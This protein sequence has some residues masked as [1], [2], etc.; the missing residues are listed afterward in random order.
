[1]TSQLVAPPR[2]VFFFSHSHNCSLL[3][4]LQPRSCPSKLVNVCC[5][6]SDSTEAGA[7]VSHTYGPLDGSLYATVTK[8]P[9]TP[10]STQPVSSSSTEATPVDG[11]NSVLA[12]SGANSSGVNNSTS[13]GVASGVVVGVG[14]CGGV[15]S[16]VGSSVV[17]NGSAATPDVFVN[18]PHTVSMDSGISSA[19]NGPH[20]DGHL[21]G[22]SSS[23]PHSGRS[24]G[25]SSAATFASS[26][27]P[28]PPPSSANP[29]PQTL[30]NG[31]HQTGVE[32]RAEVH[33]QPAAGPSLAD[34][35]ALDE[36]LNDM[37]LTV[38]NIPDLK[39]S[40]RPGLEDLDLDLD[41]LKVDFDFSTPKT[42]EMTRSSSYSVTS[43]TTRYPQ[44]SSYLTNGYPSPTN[45]PRSSLTTTRRLDFHSD[46]DE[47]DIPYHA[48]QDSRP[49]TY[50]V[51]PGSPVLQRK[52][53]ATAAS[54]PPPRRDSKEALQN[55]PGLASPSLVRKALAKNT[56]TSAPPPSTATTSRSA[57][58]QSPTRT[59]PE[60]ASPTRMSA[61]TS[62]YPQPV[63]YSTPS[64]HPTGY[65]TT[66]PSSNS[67]HY[68]QS[69][70]SQNNSTYN[71]SPSYNTYGSPYVAGNMGGGGGSFDR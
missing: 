35:R 49:F 47:S 27:A 36:L 59:S 11:G 23:P 17:Q 56:V 13:G 2:P 43:T 5:L 29:H 60:R 69:I 20:R 63:S 62:G 39:P 42:N 68:Q 57:Q 71:N 30:S 28:P 55:H 51:V 21:S 70:Y 25:S 52:Q 64:H 6:V 15:T 22:S 61:G 19:G 45:P 50:G 1:M 7:A 58:R 44:N 67:M 26:S 8:K 41:S 16:G 65:G 53:F 18:S 54:P 12:P 33:S 24:A 10:T 3:F 4:P 34:H 9:T 32:T 66:P 31:L 48:R 14:A 37:L 38:E 40:Q 46:T